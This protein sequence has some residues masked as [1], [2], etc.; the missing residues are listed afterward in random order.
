MPPELNLVLVISVIGFLAVAAFAASRSGKWRSFA[1]Q[2]ACVLIFS[3]I[4]HRLFDFPLA[5]TEVTAKGGETNPLI[6]TVALYLCMVAGMLFQFLYAHF[7]QK[8]AARKS[9][10]WGNFLAPVF[11][12]PIVFIPLQ[13]ALQGA[14]VDLN[15][16]FEPR[17]MLFLVAFQNGFFWKDFFDRQ[18]READKDHD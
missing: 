7:L 2:F 10:D 14:G 11:A 8:K 16:Q 4:L 18:R 6:V 1:F 17:V 12:S 3:L 9:W 13:S 15:A 5:K